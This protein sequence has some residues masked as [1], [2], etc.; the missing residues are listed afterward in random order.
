[1]KRITHP[2]GPESVRGDGLVVLHPNLFILERV[3]L[4]EFAADVPGQWINLSALLDVLD[5]D[6]RIGFLAQ[7][8]FQ[9]DIDLYQFREEG[10]VIIHVAEVVGIVGVEDIEVAGGAAFLL[11]LGAAGTQHVPVGRGGE[12]VVNGW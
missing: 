1:M 3:A 8:W 4:A 2:C 5:D 11:G 6:G 7:Q 9:A 10:L 12:D